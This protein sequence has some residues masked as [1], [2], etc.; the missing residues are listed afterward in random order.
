MNFKTLNF[1]FIQYLLK[2]VPNFILFS[3]IEKS[4]L[5]LVVNYTSLYLVMFFFKKHTQILISC[6]SDITA[7]DYPGK[8]LRFE[9]FYNCFSIKYNFRLRI[10]TLV[11]ELLAVVSLNK[12][13]LSSSWWEREVWDM[14]GIFFHEHL[15]LRRILTDYGFV[16]YPLRK[17]FPNVGFYEIRYSESQ[18]KVI[19]EPLE[20][21]CY[22]RFS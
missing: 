2:L 13:F 21:S 11:N 3:Y 12:L 6:I 9:L 17:D 5:T 10:K 14:F 4:E 19:Y 22:T 1:N 15:R 20:F 18:Q 7:V 16:G 8:F